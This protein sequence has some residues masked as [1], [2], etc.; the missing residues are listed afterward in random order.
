LLLVELS[1][2]V[3]KYE[4]EIKNLANKIAELNNQMVNTK[5]F[6]HNLNTFDPSF[7]P[8]LNDVKEN[9]DSQ[10]R[11]CRVNQMVIFIY[12]FAAYK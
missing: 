1:E 8:S 12:C 3:L 11:L 5:D 4:I 7:Q 9:T 10:T 2:K 6:I